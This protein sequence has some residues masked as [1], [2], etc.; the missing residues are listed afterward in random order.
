MKFVLVLVLDTASYHAYIFSN[1]D[2]EDENDDEDDWN[3]S[4]TR[5]PQPAPRSLIVLLLCALPYALCANIPH[6]A[7]RLPHSN[8]S[9]PV[10]SSQKQ[11]PGVQFPT[12]SV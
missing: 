10:T 8:D 12:F 2:Y 11:A 7:F 5:T 9:Q 1:F 6:S 4:A 3:N